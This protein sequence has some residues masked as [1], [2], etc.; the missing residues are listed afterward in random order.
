MHASFGAESGLAV[1]EHVK[2]HSRFRHPET[3]RP[4]DTGVLSFLGRSALSRVRRMERRVVVRIPRRA[5][6]WSQLPV[7]LLQGPVPRYG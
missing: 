4:N 6:V 3:R 2:G 1:L 7:R 5:R